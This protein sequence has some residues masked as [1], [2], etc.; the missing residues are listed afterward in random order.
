M[1]ES[2]HRPE[3]STRPTMERELDNLFLDISLLCAQQGLAE[4]NR[5]TF[6]PN[7]AETPLLCRYNI[8]PMTAMDVFFADTIGARLDP[9]HCY[10]E[11]LSPH[12]LDRSERGRPIRSVSLALKGTMMDGYIGFDFDYRLIREE[13]DSTID[14]S[15]LREYSHEGKV[16]KSDIFEV[17]DALMTDSIMAFKSGNY[18]LHRDDLHKLT[19]LLERLS[20]LE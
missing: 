13:T 16:F 19:R 18:P 12:S 1:R 9:N 7:E 2:Y 3:A 11:Y 6:A 5:G 14:A 4:E 8:D 15:C 20:S 17:G 10:L